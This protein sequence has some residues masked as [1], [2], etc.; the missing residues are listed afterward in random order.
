MALFFF[1]YFLKALAII[2][3]LIIIKINIYLCKVKYLYS[4]PTNK[5]AI[6]AH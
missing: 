4:F 6:Y 3:V 5:Q 2:T 1:Y